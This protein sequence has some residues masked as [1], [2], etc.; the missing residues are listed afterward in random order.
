MFD[1]QTQTFGVEI[2]CYIPATAIAANEIRIGAYHHGLQIPCFPDGW[3]AEH[4]G[5]I[6]HSGPTGMIGVE[7]VSPILKG[8]EG[9]EQM[10]LVF[11]KLNEWG[12]KVNRNCGFHIHIG[13]ADRKIADVEKIARVAAN[14]QTSLYAATGTKSREQGSYCQ[15]I[16]DRYKNVDWKVRQASHVRFHDRYMALNLTNWIEGRRPTVEFRVFAGTLNFVKAISYLRMTLATVE[17]ALTSRTTQWE[18]K[19]VAE[20]NGIKRNGN[21]QTDI[22]RFFYAMGW[23]TGRVDRPL[24]NIAA[25]VVPIEATKKELMRLARKYDGVTAEGDEQ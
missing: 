21:G 5:S 23:T 13:I 2:E 14:F 4:D 3:T 1:L 25:D 19:P 20:G 17:K 6:S 8:A 18:P 24:G 9:V 7:I 15:P 12:A 16:R 22:C 11:A 10:K